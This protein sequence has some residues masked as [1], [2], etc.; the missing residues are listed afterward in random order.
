VIENGSVRV[1]YPAGGELHFPSGIWAGDQ[2]VVLDSGNRLVRI[3]NPDGALT[4]LAG[5]PAGGFLDG[6]GA[7][8]RIAPLLGIAALGGD[9]VVADAGNYR[10]RLIEP[11]SDLQSTEVRTFAGAP[12]L[13]RGDGP[14]G[15]AGLVAPTGIA[16]KDGLVYIA[17][18]GNSLIRVARP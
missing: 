18:T 15:E 14:G 3:L 10:L 5:S 16:V 7:R 9:L 13:S 4:D 6:N 1:A 8:A 17:D 12:H 11:G 2:V